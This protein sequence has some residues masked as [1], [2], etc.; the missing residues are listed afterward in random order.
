MLFQVKVGLSAIKDL[1][2]IANFVAI[3]G[4]TENGF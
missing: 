4:W 3:F 2:R 1:F